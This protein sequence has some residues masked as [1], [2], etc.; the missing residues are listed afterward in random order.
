MV[1]VLLWQ[2]RRAGMHVHRYDLDKD[3][4]V[5][6][7]EILK[8]DEELRKQDEDEDEDEDDEDEDD[9]DPVSKCV[10]SKRQVVSC[11]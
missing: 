2:R 4:K 3:D 9:E 1:S 6:F 8:A 11:E 10:S 5:S 7:E